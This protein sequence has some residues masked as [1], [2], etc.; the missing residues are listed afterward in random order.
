MEKSMSKG[1]KKQNCCKHKN[2]NNRFDCLDYVAPSSSIPCSPI[3][4]QNK[5]EAFVCIHKRKR[6]QEHGSCFE[7][8]KS[9]LIKKCSCH[10]AEKPKRKRSK[11]LQNKK[12]T[13]LENNN[14]NIST[15]P[16][17]SY[18]SYPILDHGSRKF[19][20]H[21]TDSDWIK[22]QAILFWNFCS[23]NNLKTNPSTT[24]FIFFKSYT[25]IE[26]IFKYYEMEFLW[27][28]YKDNKISSSQF[29]F[30]NINSSPPTFSQTTYFSE[31][32]SSSS[33]EQFIK[34]LVNKIILFYQ[35]NPSINLNTILTKIISTMYD[36][37]PEFVKQSLENPILFSLSL[38][39]LKSISKSLELSK[40][41]PK[42]SYREKN[43]YLH[44]LLFSILLNGSTIIEREEL[45]NF[46]NTSDHLMNASLKH[47]NNFKLGLTSSV[48]RSFESTEI[49]PSFTVHLV[50]DFWEKFSIAWE[51][52]KLATRRLENGMK[53]THQVHFIP[54]SFDEFYE[55]FLN[56]PNYGKRCVDIHGNHRTPKE[57]FFRDL[58]PFFIRSHPDVRTGYCPLCMKMKEYLKT[59]LRILKNDCNCNKK[60]CPNGFRHFFECNRI[61]NSEGECTQCKQCYCELCLTCKVDDLKE[62]ITKFL[63]ELTCVENEIG[64]MQFPNINCLI[65]SKKNSCPS[66]DI[67]SFEVLLTKCCPSVSENLDYSTNVTTKEWK[68]KCIETTK[69]HY[70]MFALETK[71]L[72]IFDFLEKFHTFLTEKRGFIWHFYVNKAQR[73]AYNQ[74]IDNIMVGYYGERVMM[75]VADWAF[76]FTFTNGKKLSSREFFSTQKCQIFGVVDFNF[77]ENEFE[78]CSKFILSDQKIKKN[79]SNSVDDIKN[80][81]LNRKKKNE[82]INV[83]HCWSDGSTSEFMNRKMFGNMPKIASEL[84]FLIVWHFFA[85]NHGKNICDSEF[86]RFKEWLR[87][88]FIK[89][90]L[91]KSKSAELVLDFCEQK[92]ASWKCGGKQIKS[93]NFEVR[94]DDASNFEDFEPVGDTK[95]YRCL[96]FDKDGKVYRRYLSCSCK[97]C[98]TD[99]LAG[100]PNYETLCGQWELVEMKSLAHGAIIVDSVC[101]EKFEHPDYDSDVGMMGEN[102][103]D[104]F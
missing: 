55:Y 30:N 86:S 74:M 29:F 72:N 92:K 50:K 16:P 37:Y 8:M 65:N 15:P 93:R 95:M 17:I 41:D 36:S 84:G 49:F 85:N 79:A 44:T 100:C 97:S 2:C 104:D 60:N 26:N 73:F 18:L 103:T 91:G 102:E 78:S 47:I 35:Q 56:H 45:K 22:F 28:S 46:F 80:V 24:Y 83:A 51:G 69:S 19:F 3:S 61:L 12:K 4:G 87:R 94:S 76:N 10:L 67:S 1:K 25:N 81:I 98:A 96:A 13:K 62:S 77:F 27:S 53:E 52:R 42:M 7:C 82:N 57:T 63:N 21:L 71:T 101:D 54:S 11:R 39:C 68:K 58:K 90:G 64:G 88:F 40:N 38:R 5:T 31:P 43:D 6:C 20:S 9:N 32:I 66:C 75:C 33:Q 89:F 34:P 70:N 23:V 48:N 59:F 99:P 14:N